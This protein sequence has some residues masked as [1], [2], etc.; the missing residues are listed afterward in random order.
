MG[1]TGEPRE[2]QAADNSSV[3]RDQEAEFYEAVLLL[4]SR[5]PPRTTVERAVAS[6]EGQRIRQKWAFK[7]GR[8][9][10]LR[11]LVSPDTHE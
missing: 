7:Y 11:H 6:V 4:V 8:Q 1:N 2:L 5:M 9:P 10:P 3:L